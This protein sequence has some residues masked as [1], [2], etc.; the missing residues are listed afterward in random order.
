MSHPQGGNFNFSSSYS[1]HNRQY[2]HSHESHGSDKHNKYSSDHYSRGHFR[3]HSHYPNDYHNQPHKSKF[4]SFIILI[5]YKEEYEDSRQEHYSSR[6][7]HSSKGRD[8]SNSSHNNRWDRN[9]SR[10]HSRSDHSDK[11]RDQYE[12]RKPNPSN[13][14]KVFSP[15]SH[16]KSVCA[17]SIPPL[18]PPKK[19]LD[20]AQ[21]N[22]PSLQKSASVQPTIPPLLKSNSLAP[23][24]QQTPRN[25]A[26]KIEISRK[27]EEME[28]ESIPEKSHSLTEIST[29]A[30]AQITDPK[31]LLSYKLSELKKELEKPLAELNKFNEF[32]NDPLLEIPTL[33][34]SF[35]SV[36][37]VVESQKIGKALH[38][39]HWQL[40]RD[41]MKNEINQLMAEDKIKNEQRKKE[42]MDRIELNSD[43]KN[44]NNTT[45]NEEM[46]DI[47][48]KS[49]EYKVVPKVFLYEKSD[50]LTE[51][52]ALSKKVKNLESE[53]KRMELES[54]KQ[55][56][57]FA[58]M[59]AR[60]KYTELKAKL[61]DLKI[62]GLQRTNT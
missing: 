11:P 44:L 57:I 17:P 45:Q 18:D 39:E 34:P 3:H 42:L 32:I 14:S 28:I 62:N 20:P 8:S 38:G 7:K 4:I 10:S 40:D 1:S 12:H 15:L 35:L 24:S 50:Q 55:E 6:E 48:A 43:I 23:T 16:T 30:Q 22:L 2:E 36:S 27:E 51:L 41:W 21:S 60:E 31:K 33:K 5:G 26:T 49:E 46:K 59:R 9:Y 52:K 19:L 37:A 29:K 61:L 56:R 47:P 58:E 25:L 54:A 13:E 53:R